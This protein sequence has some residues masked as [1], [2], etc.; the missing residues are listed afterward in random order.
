MREKKQSVMTTEEQ[1][2]YLYFD[3][4]GN[5]QLVGPGYYEWLSLGGNYDDLV[6]AV[7]AADQEEPSDLYAIYGVG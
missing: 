5:P 1:D 2:D 6:I 3:E 7:A 4:M